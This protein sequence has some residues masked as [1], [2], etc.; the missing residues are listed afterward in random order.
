[1]VYGTSYHALADRGRL[2]A[3]ETLLVLG[4]AGGVGL[5]AVQ[6]GRALG[7]T[8]IAAAS[9]AEKLAVAREQG[10]EHLIDYAREDMRARL[11]EITGAKG[12]DV[13]FDPVGGGFSEPAF[14]A[15]GWEGRHLVVGFAGGA[16]PALPLNLPL[17]KGAS[18]VGV[19]VGEFSRREPGRAAE[20]FRTLL[21]WLEQG[22]IRP[23]V[24]ETFSLAEGASAIA[25]LA[26]RRSIGKLVVKI[27]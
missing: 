9:D 24:S 13:V 2:K 15:L 4:A 19:F 20:N 17:L 7:A 26:E 6:I 10:A 27:R 3:G 18:L 14:R 21:G 8:V 1:M 5:A 23:V 25:T 22:R 11:K 16:I 12:V